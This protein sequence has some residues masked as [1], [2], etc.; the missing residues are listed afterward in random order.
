MPNIDY[1]SPAV[2]GADMF[3]YC[4]LLLNKLIN[5]RIQELGLPAA[6]PDPEVSM[7]LDPII[8]TW[9]ACIAVLSRF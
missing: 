5:R 3:W 6:R 4:M 1:I 7:V 9:K 8:L 2:T